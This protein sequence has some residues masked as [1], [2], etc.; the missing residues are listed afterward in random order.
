MALTLVMDESAFRRARE[1]MMPSPCA[2]EK[3]MLAGACACSLAARR[4]I[5]ERE[6][7]ACGSSAA[8]EQCAA[9]RALLRQK[10]AFALKLTHMEGPLPHAKQMKLE[11]GGL[12]G[13][14][15]AAATVVSAAAGEA[16]PEGPEAASVGD[17]HRLVQACTEKFGGLANLPYSAIVQ[18]VVA[19]RIRRRR[20]ES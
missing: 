14:R 20:P 1:A 17:V 13:L 7:V 16:V 10:S 2:F 15:Q 19:Y 18:S 8:R 9:L 11:C 4:N 5:A 12:Q 3:A 6:A